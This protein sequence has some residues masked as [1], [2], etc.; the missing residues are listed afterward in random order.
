[1]S[2]QSSIVLTANGSCDDLMWHRS[3]ET[4][5]AWRFA[6][7]TNAEKTCS[8][9]RRSAEIQVTSPIF[10]DTDAW[11]RTPTSALLT[12]ATLTYCMQASLQLMPW[13]VIIPQRK[14][15]YT[16]WLPTTTT[17]ARFR[18]FAYIYVH[19]VRYQGPV[20]RVATGTGGYVSTGG[21]ARRPHLAVAVRCRPSSMWSVIMVR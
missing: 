4:A 5:D 10:S 12:A 21:Q 9:R 19:K 6:V 3:R 1:M 2:R 8:E 18:F 16:K 20:A 7:T 14:T 17:T 11:R 13:H 15:Q